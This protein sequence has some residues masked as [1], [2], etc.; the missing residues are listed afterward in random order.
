MSDE[1]R[2]ILADTWRLVLDAIDS[3]SAGSH[4]NPNSPQQEPAAA[5]TSATPS[6]GK[7]K[8]QEEQEVSILG[9]YP[10]HTTEMLY[11]AL[12]SGCSRLH[13]DA[14]L[15]RYIRARKWDPKKASQMFLHMLNWR[16]SFNAADVTVKG[17][18]ALPQWMF[19]S[20]LVFCHGRDLSKR[21]IVYL[22]PRFFDKSLTSPEHNN[23]FT[24]WFMEMLKEYYI[25]DEAEKV[26]IVLDLGGSGLNNFDM[27]IIKFLI[28]CLSDYYPESLGACLILNAPFFFWGLWKIVQPLLDPVIASKI[29]FVNKKG[30]LN[31]IH[32]DVLLNQYGGE[33][34]F[35]YAYE[36]PNESDIVRPDEQH[37]K[38]VTANLRSVFDDFVTATR[39]WI[40]SPQNAEL[41]DKRKELHKKIETAWHEF[42]QLRTPNVYV[43]F[44]YIPQ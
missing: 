32:K 22:R 35:E 28:Q 14:I 1:Q 40:P 6:K 4:P 8:K 41:L 2:Q 9:Q 5:S 38:T 16:I 23:R 24:V 11:Q 13:P 3:Q 21:P 43:R 29:E 20:G 36:P 37:V 31:F 10:A 42:D 30:L 15:L 26:T 19:K 39:D 44:K 12:W 17:E 27:D 7:N 33:N 25:G 18:T 34:A